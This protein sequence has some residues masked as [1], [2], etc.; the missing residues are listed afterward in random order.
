MNNITR[1]LGVTIV[2]ASLLGLL[3]L[4]QIAGLLS[5]V[6][7]KN[8]VLMRLH[9]VKLHGSKGFGVASADGNKKGKGKKKS[10]KSKLVDSLEDRPAKPK[11]INRP[12]VKS[13]QDALIESLS[14]KS[15]QTCIG[16]V[17]V[18]AQQEQGQIDTFWEL[19]PALIHSRFPTVRDESLQRV[20][21]MVKHALSRTPQDL[22]DDDIKQDPWRPHDEI[23]AYMPGLGPTQPFWDPTQLPI[24]QELSDNFETIRSEYLALLQDKQYRFQSVT[25]MNYDSGWKTL[26]L[27]YNGHRIP[28]FPYHLCPKT[29]QLMEKLPLAGRIAGFNRQAPSSGIPLHS[30]GN[31]MWLTLQMGIQVPEGERAWI[32]VGP[33]TRRW[34]EGECILYDTTYEHETLN[35]H[36]E[37]ERVVLHIDF[38]NNLRMTPVEI[39]AMRYIYSLREEFMKAEGV[40]K[41]GKQIL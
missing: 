22:L 10:S 11:S 39:E 12:Y 14:A 29:T 16:Q 17:V 18:Q 6:P 20:A 33:E 40:S 32:R 9:S 1:S 34:K 35:E 2:V 28:G 19:M 3:S 7:Q 5:D 41:V 13:E 36:E 24:C 30:D 37:Q 31:N 25:S 27:F 4:Q 23:H 26:V 15:S 21:G 38:F 8:N